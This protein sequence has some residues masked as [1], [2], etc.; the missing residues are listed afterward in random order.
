MLGPILPGLQ[1]GSVN[2]GFTMVVAITMRA[3]S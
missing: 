3:I 2:L 1:G